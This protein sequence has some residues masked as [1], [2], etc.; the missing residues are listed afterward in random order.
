[1]KKKHLNIISCK[2][3]YLCDTSPVVTTD[4]VDKTF[5]PATS[6][7]SQILPVLK[8]ISRNFSQELALQR[9]G[10]GREMKWNSKQIDNQLNSA[11]SFKKQS[12]F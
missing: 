6:T 12:N 10:L 8:C 7:A 5:F 11:L 4:D 9:E 1:M 3:K 2:S